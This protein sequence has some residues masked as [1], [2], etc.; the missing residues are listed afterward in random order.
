MVQPVFMDKAKTGSEFYMKFEMLDAYEAKRSLGFTWRLPEQGLRMLKAEDPQDALFTFHKY[1]V[2]HVC[3]T[4]QTLEHINC[5]IAQTRSILDGQATSGL[6]TRQLRAIENYGRA[7]DCLIDLIEQNNFSLNKETICTLHALVG[8]D[9]ARHCGKFRGHQVFIEQSSYIP[10]KSDYLEKIF[11]EGS[12]FLNS[13]GNAQEKALC[14]FLF[15]ARSQFFSDCNKRTANLVMN[16]LLM[17]ACFYPLNIQGEQFLE[18]MAAF[19]ETADA[20]EV[21]KEI[22]KIAIRQYRIDGAEIEP[23]A[24]ESQS[25]QQHL[26]DA[27]NIYDAQLKDFM[28]AKSEQAD[29]LVVNL[30]NKIAAQSQKLQNVLRAKPNAISALWR[31]N[32]WREQYSQEQHRLHEQEARLSRVKML[33]ASTRRLERMAETKLRRE[34]KGLTVRRDAQLLEERERLFKEKTQSTPLDITR[35]RP[36]RGRSLRREQ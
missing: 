14:S 30:E 17:Q 32:Q 25:E 12:A 18:K 3:S 28:Q 4:L 31:G 33:Q 27:K 15:L 21:I 26:A 11:A 24:Q 35:K 13:L 2:E 36:G 19:Y 16:G 34:Q 6:S 5:T 1:R 7:C 10:P 22:N 20:T 9:E 8:R 29:R 23:R